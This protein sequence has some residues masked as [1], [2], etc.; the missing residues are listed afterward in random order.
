MPDSP[1]ADPE[2]HTG[3]D[4]VIAAALVQG[5]SYPEAGR[6]AGVSS[7]TVQRRMADST[8]AARVTAGRLERASDITA[9]LGDLGLK[10]VAVL[11]EAMDEDQPMNLRLAAAGASLRHLREFRLGKEI[12]ERL[13]NL[14]AMKASIDALIDEGIVR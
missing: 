9:R 13:R 8:F 5:L 11:D 3:T 10:A 2:K 6:L 7:K 12:D 1:G 14:E 4:D